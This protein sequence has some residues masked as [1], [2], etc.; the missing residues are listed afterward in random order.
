MSA[1]ASA[2]RTRSRQRGDP[3]LE[4]LHLLAQLQIF[5][6]HLFAPRRKVP[7]VFPPVESDLLSLVDGT[8]H[9]ADANREQL[10]FSEGD[11]DV[12]GH[13]EPFVEDAIENVNQPGTVAARTPCEISRHRVCAEESARNFRSIYLGG[14]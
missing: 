8:N 12:A 3:A 5:L 10:D 6:Q 2:S 9:E 14:R 7:I 13:H 11:L 4:P 1:F